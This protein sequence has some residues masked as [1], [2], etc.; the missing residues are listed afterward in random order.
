MLLLFL[1][2]FIFVSSFFSFSPAEV[3]CQQN[4]ADS[5]TNLNEGDDLEIKIE[6]G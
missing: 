1:L 6:V 3:F 2:N 4:P 5:F